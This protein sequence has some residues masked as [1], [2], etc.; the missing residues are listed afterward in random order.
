M[1][2]SQHFKQSGTQRIYMES[3]GI[4]EKL[5]TQIFV[6]KVDYS[7]IIHQH[8]SPTTEYFAKG[9][10]NCKILSNYLCKDVEN[11]DDFECPEASK[12]ISNEDTIWECSNYPFRHKKTLHCAEKKTYAYGSWVLNFFDQNLIFVKNFMYF[13]CNVSY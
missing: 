9:L 6:G 4:M 3:I 1:T 11:M 5:I 12:L 2:T 13:D 8:C 10:E 7:T